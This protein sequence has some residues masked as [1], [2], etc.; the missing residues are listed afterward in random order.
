MTVT[1][2]A[3]YKFVTLPE[4]QALRDALEARCRAAAM[5]GTI[6]VAPEGI[7]GT[8][9]GPPAAIADFFAD[10]RSDPRFADL[11]VKEATAGDH[12]FGRLKV[13]LKPEIVTF[14]VPEADPSRRV[15]TYVPPE[16]WNALIREPDVVVVDTRNSYEFA[17]GTFDGAI[18]PGT[19]TFGEF[20]AW[21]DRT[22]DPR[23]TPRVAMFCTGGIRCEK[24][25]SYLLMRGFS[26]VYHL[27]GGILRYL[28]TVPAEHS[29]WRGACFVFDDRVAVGHGLA[30]ARHA[31]CAACGQPVPV[32]GPGD[33]AAT[34]AV[35]AIRCPACAAGD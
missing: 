32:A 22:L 28:E 33:T 17:V 26:E 25:T 10:L 9:S 5:R 8:I 7:N 11:V 24:A 4:P 13:K 20:P 35:T 30:I 19:R 18:D 3:F 34:A 21:A 27:E 6:L 14:G 2:S 16:D 23:R 15:G 29:L 12:P 1:V 31:R